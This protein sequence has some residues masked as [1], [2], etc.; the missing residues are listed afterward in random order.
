MMAGEP[1]YR[2]RDLRR[3]T[4]SALDGR[5]MSGMSA[6]AA[7]EVARR[8]L[9]SRA[10]ATV[11]TIERD[12]W[13]VAGGY[14]A[15]R[16]LHR[17]RFEDPAGSVIYVS[18]TT[19][20]V[21]LDTN[22]HERFWNWVG[23]VPHWIYFTELRK[24]GEAWRQ[25][26]LWTSGVGMVGAFTGL[27]IGIL[28][29]KLKR[30]YHGHE[31]SPYRGWM[32]WHHIG[33]LVAGLT[34]TTWIVSGWLSVN[35]N[36]WFERSSPDPAGLERY[37]GAGERFPLDLGKTHISPALFPKE[38]R[39]VWVGGRPVVV[40]TDSSRRRTLIDARTG[41]TVHLT[42]TGLFARAAALVPGAHVVERES[43]DREDLYWYAHHA[44]TRLPV[45]RVKFDDP[46]RTWFH[47]DA[48]TGEVL[49]S[50]TTSDRIERWAFNFLH[51]FDLPVLLHTRPSWD[52]LVWVLS[53][54]GLVISVSSVV[55]GWRRLKRKAREVEGWTRRVGRKRPK[56]PLPSPGE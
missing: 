13:T 10:P 42:R 4:V 7:E 20:E 36:N 12:Q 41:E 28:R 9:R 44:D 14:D 18:S 35:P 39:F 49:G 22:A 1:V 30:R 51:D 5:M 6:K 31:V 15:H 16:P 21:V 25:V 45:L 48:V 19:G 32:K 34:L 11:E 38:A 50:M 29:L 23:T 26:I 55:I 24:D 54:G 56:V 3:V 47:I 43:L 2:I 27:W 46:H 52:I 37:A 53:I 33:G 17:V 40:L 8:F